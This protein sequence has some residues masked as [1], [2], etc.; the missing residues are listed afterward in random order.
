MVSDQSKHMDESQITFKMI[1][2]MLKTDMKGLI[3][4]SAFFGVK[5]SPF[6]HF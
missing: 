4:P 2:N 3:M 5:A 6:D 1:G